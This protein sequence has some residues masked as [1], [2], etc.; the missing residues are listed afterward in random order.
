L[1][2]E[3]TDFEFANQ[4]E[5]RAFLVVLK[6]TCSHCFTYYLF[7]AAVQIQ[8]DFSHEREPITNKHIS[9]KPENCPALQ[10]YCDALVKID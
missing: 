1:I 9:Q 4:D 10:F 8:S 5:R 7:S 3:H 6:T 2:Y